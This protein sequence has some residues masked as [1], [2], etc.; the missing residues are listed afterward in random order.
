[1]LGHSDC[2]AVKATVEVM[3]TGAVLPGHLPALI[4]AI[5]PAVDLAE[6]ARATDPLAEAIAQNVRH[7]VRH[8]E[9][10]GP[11]IA[12]AVAREQVKV[13]GG[14]YDIATG[15]VRLV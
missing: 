15:Q 2:G 10:A 5:R 8:L 12:E 4:D 3:K 11:I 6:K 14:F 13:V 7:G 1:V 9:G